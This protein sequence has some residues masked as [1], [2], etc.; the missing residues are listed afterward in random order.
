MCIKNTKHTLE[1]REGIE[2]G[3]PDVAW[4]AADEIRLGSTS[5]IGKP[6]WPALDIGTVDCKLRPLVT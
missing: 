4:V 1:R 3:T 2:T 6:G 5:S